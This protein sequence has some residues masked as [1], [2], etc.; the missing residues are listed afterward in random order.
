[1]LAGRAA[2]F[3]IAV[4][5][6]NAPRRF[7]G[8]VWT[9]ARTVA[10]APFTVAP[11][12]ARFFVISGAIR[13]APAL[14]PLPPRARPA[15]T[16]YRL[17]AKQSVGTAIP[18]VPAGKAVAVAGNAFGSGGKTLTLANARVFA[19]FVPDGGARLVVFAQ[20]SQRG[21]NATNATGA[22][23][24]DVLVQPPLSTTDRIAKYTHSYPAG[25]YN[26]PYG[27][28]IVATGGAD[29]VVRFRY[30][31]ADLG[32]AHIEKTVRLAADATRLIV[33]ER[34]SFDETNAAQRAVVLDAVAAA[35]GD[36]T[37]LGSTFVA[38]DGTDAVAITWNPTA[39]DRA[40][41]TRYGSNGTLTLVAA[42]NAWR[43]TYALSHVAGTANVRAFAQEERDWLAA[44]PNPP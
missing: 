39:V 36:F 25:T 29:A 21:Y 4:N 8:P 41:W 15:R 40:T 43:T 38:S 18:R 3:G 2:T 37:D 27:T 34:V 11:R 16:E 31:A 17:N 10:V 12:D 7:A 24:D 44:N 32:G 33:D 9:G 23:R 35:P 1:V 26:R 30:V 5:W 19:V 28:T 14:P 20:R 22:L 13:A 42:Q 6:S